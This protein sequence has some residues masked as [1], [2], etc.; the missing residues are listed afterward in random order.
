AFW[1]TD[2]R[3]AELLQHEIRAFVDDRQFVDAARSFGKLK[4][5]AGQRPEFLEKTPL[6]QYRGKI[7]ESI[8]ALPM[9]DILCVS[10]AASELVITVVEGISVADKTIPTADIIGAGSLLGVDHPLLSQFS[11]CIWNSVLPFLASVASPC[12]VQRSPFVLSIAQTDSQVGMDVFAVASS[13]FK[14]LAHHMSLLCLDATQLFTDSVSRKV[15]KVL[16]QHLDDKL[17]QNSSPEDILRFQTTFGEMVETY[18]AEMEQIGFPVTSELLDSV[19]VAF[20]VVVDKERHGL[21]QSFHDI[22]SANDYSIHTVETNQEIDRHLY[23]FPQ[24]PIHTKTHN[25][26]ALCDKVLLESRSCSVYLQGEYLN[27]LQ[28]YLDLILAASANNLASRH[29]ASPHL[30]MMYHND[31]LC[32][33]HRCKLWLS[34]EKP[35][36]CISWADYAVDFENMAKS[37]Y[38]SAIVVA[39]VADPRNSNTTHCVKSYWMPKECTLNC[40]TST[41]E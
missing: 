41:S 27:V 24:C 23:F 13:I 7:L 18:Q 31:S 17:Q 14:F 30:L 22:M 9:Q 6:E 15:T 21:L 20:S 8:N 40:Q 29:N 2:C 35:D 11:D 32:I 38:S 1:L 12:L 19:K 25:L 26:L 33:A 3:K 39:G 4:A 28:D 5:L 37:F 10:R 36:A 16:K 34:S